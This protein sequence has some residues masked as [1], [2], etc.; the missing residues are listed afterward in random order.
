ME[1]GGHGSEQTRLAA[2]LYHRMKDRYAPNGLAHFGQGKWYP[3]EQLPRWSLNCYWRKDGEPIWANPKLIADENKN[4]TV[5]E[6]DAQRFLA[7]VAAELGSIQA[8]RFPA[9]EDAFYYLWRERRLPSNVDPFDSE[10]KD[11]MERARLAKV[12]EQGLGRGHRPRAADRAYAGRSAVADGPWFLRSERCYLIPGDSPIGYRLPLD[13]QPW[14]ASGD[15]P[16]IHAPDPSRRFL[17]VAAC[18][19]PPAVSRARCVARR[20]RPSARPEFKE[21]AAALTRTSMCAEVRNGVLYIFMPPARELDHY[22]ELVAAV[23]AAAEALEQPII[24]E[25]YEPPS[26][27]RIEQFQSDAGSR[28]HRSERAAVGELGRDGG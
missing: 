19:N 12:F 26:D 27:P 22:V 13:S 9:Y 23:E 6:A 21:S 10:L 20:R 5:T 24:I 11:P 17:R 25:G 3:G 8:L 4:Y 1:H 15:Y 16:F 14:T 7:R 2:A 18:G 28:R